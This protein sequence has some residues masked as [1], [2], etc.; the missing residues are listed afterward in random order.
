MASIYELQQR[1]KTLR[2]KTETESISPEEVGGLHADTL[3]YIAAMEQSADGL[4][5]RK[6]YAT[7][8]AM[9]AD[10]SPVGTNGKTLRYGQLVTVFDS[11]NPTQAESGNVYAW[12]KPGW[13]L[14][15]NMSDIYSLKAAIEAEAQAR[16]DGDASA[17]R[18]AAA[19]MS[20]LSSHEKDSS[21]HVSAEDRAK[22]NAAAGLAIPE[23]VVTGTDVT[24]ADA[25]GVTLLFKTQE[26]AGGDT[27][28]TESRI[29]GAT[30]SAAGVMTASDKQHLEE[31]R[32]S[33]TL[34]FSGF[35]EGVTLLQQSAATLEGIYYERSS[36]L[37]V[38]KLGE[39][40]YQSWSTS[41][42]Y[43]EGV[44]AIRKDRV[45]LCGNTLYVWSDTA[46][47][48][49]SVTTE[50]L[51]G[52]VNGIA[53]LGADRTVPL[54]NL[55]ID[56]CNVIVV[57]YWDVSPVNME[58]SYKYDSSSAT[59]QQC[60][61]GVWLGVSLRSDV[62][63]VDRGNRV[64]YIWD[65]T[66]MTA[67]A[68][69][70]TPAS[71]YNVNVALN[72][73]DTY[74]KIVDNDTQSQSAAHVS[75]AQGV[76]VSGLIL[77]FKI[78]Q[79][80]W[81]TYQYTGTEVTEAKW[82]DETNW[83]DFGSLAAGSETY[84]VIDNLVGSPSV[85]EYYTLGTAVTALL[86]YEKESGVT[87]AK[88]GLIISYRTGENTMETK[89][90]Q[91]EITDIG[92]TG[93]W[94]DFGGGSKVET[95]DTPEEDGEDALSTG[96]AYTALPTDLKVDTEEEGV[97]KISMV[98]AKGDTVGNEQQFTVGTGS[99]ESSGTIVTIIPET[100][101]IYGQAG[102]TIT[103]KASIRSVTK[104]SGEEL[105]N[106]IERVELYDR[107]TNQLLATY[108]LN[109]ASSADSG[110]YDFIFD[111]SG[112]FA[113]A[114]SRKM[115]L[116]A[117]DDSDHSGSRNLNVTAVDVTISS[118]QTLNY[119][120]ATVI[121]KGGATKNLP[122]YRF[123]NNASDK[124][125]L[126]TTE[127]CLN[128]T[129]QTLGT[130]VIS[131]TYSHSISVNP[132]DC[133]GTVLKHGAYAL[134]IHGVDVASGVVGNY[135][136]TAIMVVE[137]DNTTPIVVTRW[138]SETES[139]EVKQYETVQMDFAAY[140]PAGQQTTVNILEVCGG[141][142]TVK[143]QTT[144]YRTSTYTYTQRVQGYATDG[145][146]TFTL[147][148]Q[149]GSSASQT[150]DFKVSGTLLDI[151]SVSA[152]LM[153]DIDLQ[154]RSNS[155]TDKGITYGDY[156]LNVEGANYST[157]GF[158]K[159]SY[160]TAEYGTESDT[161]VMA[162]RIAE[163]VK[164]SLDYKPFNQAAIE[165]NG[166]AVQFRIRTRH[167][168]DDDARLMSCI[169]D[170]FGFYVTGKNVVFTFDNAATVAHTITAA[171]KD[172]T[173]TDVAIVI[174]PSSQAPYSG[175]GVAK[176]FFDGELIGA[177]YYEK[178][179][180]GKHGMPIAFDGTS[181]DLYLY[182]IRAWETY[183][184][185]EQAFDNYLLKLAD[186]DSMIT[187]YEYNQ[188]M[189]SQSAEGKP[190]TNRPQASLLYAL[191]IPY[192]VVCKN[193][194][195]ADTTDN[196]P[197]YLETLDGDKKTKRYYDIYAY[198]PDRPWQDFKAV[199]VPV[200]NQGTTSSKRPI[201]NI[202]MKFK[203][204]EVTLLHDASEFSG[205]EL[206]KYNE[207]AANAAKSR[208]QP[209]D[210]SLP[211]NIITVKV[212]YSE[213][214]GA[215]N[216]A[217][218][219]LYNELQRALGS[220]YMTPAQNAYTGKYELNTSIDSVPCAFFR[221][222]P[223]SD[224][225]TSPSYGYFHAK[226]NWND[227]K[228]DAKVFG[229]EDVPGFNEGCLNY[230]DFIELIA[231]RGQSL[232]DYEAT[233][234]KSAWD[235]AQVYVL[236]EF[237][238]P[239]HKVFR[240]QN[241]TWTETTGT[242]TY[243]SGQWRISGDVVNPVENY[244]LLVYNGM[245]W[246]QGVNSVDDM[247]AP[248]SDAD[249]T[250]CWLTYFES[251]YPD[252]DDLNAAYED[253]RKVPYY[254][255][256]WLEWCQQ[257]N[258][259]L[260]EADGDIT[261]DGTTVS[262]TAANRLL[263]FKHELHKIANVHSMICYHIFTDYIAAVDQRS[264]NMMVGFYPDTDGVVRMYLNHLYDGDTILGSDNDCGL[265]IPAKLDP[266]NDPNG[267]YQGH[268]SVLFTQLAKSD[269][270]WLQDY[271]SDSD[272]GDTTKTVTVAS[273]AA[274]MRTVQISSGL[275]PFSPQGIEKYWITDRLQKWPK[276]VSSYDGI[277][278]YI[279]NSKAS[280]N[281]FYALHGL[282]IQRLQDYVQT[283]FL[284]RDGFYQCGDVFSSMAGMR[285]TGTDMSV[286]IKAAKD[287]Y[288]GLGVDRANEARES[289]Y[290]KEGE[291]ATLHSGNTNTGSGVM[292]YIFGAENVAELDLRNATPRNESW[293]ISAM[294]LLKKLV[295]GG[296]GYTP[297]ASAGPRIGSLQLGQMP[298]LEEIDVR[299]YPLTEINAS[300]CPRLKSVLATGSQL[301]TLT[302]AE[303]S[304]VETLTLPGTLTDANFVNLPKLTYPGGLSIDGLS[305]ITRINLSGCPKI[306][307]AGFLTDCVT[308]GAK[309]G[310]V[311][312]TGLT[313]TGGGHAVL[314]ALIA[315][316]AIGLAETGEAMDES[317]QCS[318]LTGVWTLAEYVDDELFA[319]YKEYFP[320]LT[321]SQPE[322]TMIEF[323]D[324]VEDDANVSNHDNKTGYKY[325]TDYAPSGHIGAILGRRH[326]V[327][328]KVTKKATTRSVTMA[329]VE[330]TMN[331]LDGEMTYCALDDGNSN[332][333][334]DGTEAKLDG[335]E[336]DWM[337]YEPF[338]WMKGVND[339]LNGKHYSCYNSNGPDAKPSSPEATVLTLADIKATDGGYLTGRKLMTGKETLPDS[340]STDSSYS[341][342]RVT[343][344]G[345]R[346][347]RWPSVPG[348]NLVGSVF[349]DAEGNIV[350]SVVVPTLNN[351]FEAGMYLIKD[352][353]EGAAY[354][355]FSI[356]NT[357]EFDCV[358]LS[359][360]ERIED[361]EPEWV[362]SEEHLCAVVGSTVVGEKLRSAVTG[363]STAS[364]MGWTDFHYYSAQR[365]MQQI[366]ALMHSRI[367]NLFYAKYGRRD[368]QE[369]C[370]AG[371]HSSSRVTGGTASRG[372]T[373]TIG[374][375]EAY[376]VNSGVTNSLVD[377]MVHQYAW[378]K[379][380]GTA[381]QVNN[382]CCMGYEDIY[383]NKYD[384]MDGV[385]LPNDSGN[386]GK[387]RIWMPD[388]TTR[389]VQGKTTSDQWTT[390]V[391][392]GKWMDV[393]P[394]GNVNGS[395]STHYADK[396]WIST[397]AGRVVYRGYN[398]ANANG[399]VSSAYASA[400]ASHSDALVGSRLAF[401]G[402]IV[403]AESVAAYKSL[404]EV[405]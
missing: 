32:R 85:G 130:A 19:A 147:V 171:L 314:D 93:L 10:T 272:T 276:L 218:T 30:E 208:V 5:I 49:V 246:F 260:T 325:G 249:S 228:G 280:A 241:E 9:E 79:S 6:V 262:G 186:T 366:D 299:N 282:S 76:A 304:P 230:G 235:T 261:L 224:D 91:G 20:A 152:Q 323:D 72:K 170:G 12:Q 134:R 143:Q 399:G 251:R 402:K 108:R 363:G 204:C 71:I 88:K 198:F 22:W 89:Q 47:N 37:F 149:A 27:D 23:V 347:V 75:W 310:K 318:G 142:Q 221:T 159:D 355:H 231:A 82:T 153:V 387:W 303:T 55:P 42:V 124:G 234:D 287:G 352:V 160:G 180:M 329:G 362:A 243:T 201:K 97:V 219:Q 158:V 232:S 138:L 131:D 351:K 106:T 44:S 21:S 344:A 326:R 382:T 63:Y 313:V 29:S 24:I 297:A 394:V 7:V 248:K 233:L 107:D 146:V 360:S 315:S 188:V 375:E 83:Q 403:E 296:E 359:D 266:N 80:L 41:Q 13:L 254:L 341:V 335:T 192:F 16:E 51:I 26:T 98:N 210:H 127:I 385:D 236:S 117:Y 250:P 104:L 259:N 181:G 277:R 81:K 365:G 99:G 92:E 398:N 334:A 298:F 194:D 257:C 70:D 87:Y 222:D 209:T 52:A 330:T 25:E 86:A 336:G 361:M 242:M 349:T 33:G 237:C 114:G 400:G 350:E 357:A 332:Q 61:A 101:P 185:F 39:N 253:G 148:A 128:G 113:Q 120:A 18:A 319:S 176:M 238:G 252:D 62:I 292:L 3:A 356:L 328:A 50:E 275:R 135:L 293:D 65:G 301:Q 327:L 197:D 151:E 67:I 274:T 177:C 389:M 154:N 157:N 339:H 308:A 119:T 244:E 227:D 279:E 226:G 132:N 172:D 175:I 141:T 165:T 103:L 69:K 369:Q 267:Y 190:A 17:N 270:V 337:M 401:R 239:L 391:A 109:Q 140:N 286:T 358:V 54:A 289:V 220:D 396:Y 53:P 305:G 223:S 164:A 368:S 163:N 31:L 302:L 397:A 345:R 386:A 295:I 291:T 111:L 102:G 212:D 183:Y 283:R 321:L 340:Y 59:L 68:P 404:T 193:P 28:G 307:T 96:G 115:K 8:S 379:E 78:G 1:A 225:A 320:M 353:P 392:H 196:Y 263:K 189:A 383:G 373:D 338:F 380:G 393:V 377:N 271:V 200:T 342:C 43:N 324:T 121:A 290:L 264:K 123:A 371:Q 269:Y 206:E 60:S 168:A 255:Y 66:E 40:Y 122:M 2:E 294:T 187:E 216:G 94:K 211:T 381:T 284:Y 156:T 333:Y 395:S 346:R 11:A 306:D 167:I 126:C 229:F 105:T 139:A 367:A 265:T 364:G 195:T 384:M 331:E 112:Y 316:D 205:E 348:T 300:L 48:L 73:P 4:G 256:K 374:Y 390:A 179:T 213:S 178:G 376:T 46:D 116:V 145:S 35:V 245:D 155:D 378:Y 84:I 405:A 370:G 207:C 136:H 317:G 372:M 199:N 110:T 162:L 137:Q 34:R 57:D 133:L 15:G 38:A 215:N 14:M 217:S 202:K 58:G 182:N 95:K 174:E 278:K 247:L 388:G 169:S 125:I 322:Y 150:A 214:G 288:F 90:F 166:M 56:I 273:I 161:G 258:H 203:G 354:L 77:S 36:R 268:D 45:Y 240:Y 129:W 281:Y 191:G 309:V 343:V 285:C 74:Y 184:S 173:I 144:A 118:V 311:R 312:A 64:P 100:S